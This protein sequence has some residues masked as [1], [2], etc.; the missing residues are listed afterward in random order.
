M[1]FL[2][3]QFQSTTMGSGR[4]PHSGQV[5]SAGERSP[6]I[7]ATVPP[8]VP[9]LPGPAPPLPPCEVVDEQEMPRI[10]NAARVSVLVA[11]GAGRPSG[12]TAHPPHPAR[13]R[14]RPRR[15]RAIAGGM[16]RPSEASWVEVAGG[17]PKG[18]ASPFGVPIS[19]S[20]EWLEFMVFPWFA[21]DDV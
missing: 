8:D 20:T 1:G 2:S 17:G 3:N 5:D 16:A 10:A 9:P 13:F 18:E 15:T 14:A 4:R 6:R 21:F 7:V 12:R 11:W 19:I